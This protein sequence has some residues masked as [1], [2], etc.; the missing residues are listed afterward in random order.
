MA[1]Q[2]KPEISL[3]FEI[4]NSATPEAGTLNFQLFGGDLNKVESAQVLIRP[5]HLQKTNFK[6]LKNGSKLLAL[7]KKD[8]N[9]FG[10]EKPFSDKNSFNILIIPGYPTE[11]S[12]R[13]EMESELKKYDVTF[14]AFLQNRF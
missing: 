7:I 12:Q 1:L 4:K 8:I 9:T 14:C 10:T 2:R 5:H 11:T 6:M 13:V 3:F